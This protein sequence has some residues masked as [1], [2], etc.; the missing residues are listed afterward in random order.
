[1]TWSRWWVRRWRSS[2]ILRRRIGFEPRWVGFDTADCAAALHSSGYSGQGADDDDRFRHGAERRGE[3][4]LVISPVGDPE[5]EPPSVL[6]QDDDSVSL[7][8]S[9]TTSAAASSAR[10]REF[11]L[12]RTSATQTASL[13]CDC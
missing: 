3:T 5:A 11:E 9:L 4:A 2:L 10:V 6:F 8:Q 12:R 13:R 1:M 7:G